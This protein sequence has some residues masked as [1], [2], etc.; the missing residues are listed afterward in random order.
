[1]SDGSGTGATSRLRRLSRELLPISGGALGG[2]LECQIEQA[3]LAVIVRPA[4][5]VDLQTVPILRNALTAAVSAGRH[6]IVDLSNVAYIDSTGFRELLAHRRLCRE[7]DLLM[8]LVNPR[9]TV[10]KVIDSLNFYQMLSLF[11]SVEAA[12]A[13]LSALKRPA[14][15]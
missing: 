15:R 13:S 1:M 8:V 11:P 9:Q 5:E 12:L 14:A 10:R 2:L 4:G 3:A 6:V 7:R